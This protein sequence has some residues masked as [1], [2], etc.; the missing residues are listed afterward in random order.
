MN[1]TYNP[2][3]VVDP[4]FPLLKVAIVSG[5]ILAVILVILMLTLLKRKS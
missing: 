4:I 3:M 5:L 2:Y 1:E